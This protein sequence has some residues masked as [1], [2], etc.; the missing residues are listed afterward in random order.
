[1][2]KFQ[3]FLAKNYTSDKVLEVKKM[4]LETFQRTEK[5]YYN[6]LDKPPDEVKPK[7]LQF[8][9]KALNC[10]ID[11]ILNQPNTKPQIKKI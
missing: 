8:F 10:K 11:D 6:T 5:T 7:Y 4:F 9:A 3:K 2:E 1:M